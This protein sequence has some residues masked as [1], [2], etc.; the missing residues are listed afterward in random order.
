MTVL[1]FFFCCDVIG[2]EFEDVESIRDGDTLY[3]SEGTA[4]I[5]VPKEE[6]KLLQQSKVLTRGLSVKKDLRCYSQLT[7]TDYS[8]LVQ[9]MMEDIERVLQTE[10][11]WNQPTYRYDVIMNYKKVSDQFYIL[12]SVGEIRVPPR[13]IYVN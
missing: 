8:P 3:I 1:T 11:G 13:E 12:K 9:A 10:D 6:M 2:T 4:F 7:K 5:Q